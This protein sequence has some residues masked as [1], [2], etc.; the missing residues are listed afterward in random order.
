MRRCV[1]VACLVVFVFAF[2]MTAQAGEQKVLTN[3]LGYEA[4][5]PKH[6]VILGQASDTFSNCTLKDLA[7]DEAFLVVPARAEGA[8]AKWRDWY[9]WS[10]DFDSLTAEGQYYLDCASNRGSIRSSPCAPDKPAR[11]SE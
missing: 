6:F 9:F 7:S 8:V 3:H 2:G 11:C 1:S 10:G 4:S 5:G